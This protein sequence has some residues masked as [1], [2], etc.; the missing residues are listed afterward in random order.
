MSSKIHSN[1]RTENSKRNIVAA[2]LNRGLLIVLPFIARSVMLMTLGKS[3]LGLGSLFTSILMVLNLSELGF[4]SALV[5]SMYKPVAENDETAIKAL[6]NLYKKIYRIVGISVLLLG[7]CFV[8]FLPYI[9]K[10]GTPSDINI[11]VLY[12]IFLLNSSVSYFFFAHKNALLVANQK[13]SIISNT[14]TILTII[15]NVVQIAI[16]IFWRN[17]Y[18]YVIVYPIVSILQNLIIARTTTKLYPNL[19][20]EGC[21][22]K[23]DKNKIKNHVKGIA[24]QKFCSTSR[25]SFD[26]IVVSMYLGLVAIGIYN[27]YFLIM[28]SIHAFLYQIPNAI[29]ASVGNSIASESVEKN[30]KDLKKFSFLYF[31]IGAWCSVC[32]LCLYQPFMNLWMGPDM[33]LPLSSVVLFCFY[34]LELSL[35]DIISLYKDAAGLWWHGRYR[36]IIEAVANLILNFVL[37]YFYGINGILLASVVTLLFIGFGYGGYIVFHHYFSIYSVKKYF[38][39]LGVF[40]FI[41]AVVCAITYYVCSLISLNGILLLLCRAIVCVVLPNVIMMLVYYKT[42][43]FRDSFAFVKSLIYKR[44]K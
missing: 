13:S 14:N 38:A 33:L 34:F 21:V 5:Y 15:T 30:Y 28:S 19:I 26:S 42:T 40:L 25:N 12:F 1:T 44:D 11:Y 4:G 29:R 32:L 16:L 17:Y 41:T 24:L 31:W 36:T 3:Y 43:V 22:S 27:N 6:L 37:G 9:I 18:A 7:V 39:T 20:C 8:P 2:M 35:C 10:E 23:E